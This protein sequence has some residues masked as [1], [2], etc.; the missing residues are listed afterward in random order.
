MFA[1]GGVGVSEDVGDEEGE[2]CAECSITDVGGED[3]V[4]VR[5]EELCY[6]FVTKREV[7]PPA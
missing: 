4:V 7:M 5:V 3:V 6:R 1:I 2:S